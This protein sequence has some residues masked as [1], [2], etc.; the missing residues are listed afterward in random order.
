MLNWLKNI[1]G[2][3]APKPKAEAPK[4]V[5]AKKPAKPKKQAKKPA[6]KKTSIDLTSM[7]KNELLAHAKK[8]GAKANASM[9]KD[10]II[11]AIK[12]VS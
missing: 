8:A 11:D 6:A 1:L 12:N 5:Q 3:A 2:V 10:E 4:P 7:K 9:K